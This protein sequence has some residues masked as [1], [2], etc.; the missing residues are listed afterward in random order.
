MSKAIRCI[1]LTGKKF[2]KLT[3]VKRQ[4]NHIT[5]SGQTK[6]MWLCLCDCGN[7]TIVSSQDLKSGHTKSCGCL[8]TKLRGSGL[9]DLIQKIIVMNLVEKQQQRLAGCANATVEI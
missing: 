1:D 3:V 5:P 8:P 6:A 7:E 9:I 2:G 4:P